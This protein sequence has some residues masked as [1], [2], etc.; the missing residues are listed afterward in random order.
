MLVT[1]VILVVGGVLAVVSYKMMSKKPDAKAPVAY[2]DTE[3]I[4]S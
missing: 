3:K 2:G 4:L 1:F